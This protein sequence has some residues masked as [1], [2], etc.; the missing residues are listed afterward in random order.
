MHAGYGQL[1][2]RLPVFRQLFDNNWISSYNI[3]EI[4]HRHLGKVCVDLGKFFNTFGQNFCRFGQAY[5]G[6]LGKFALAQI[7]KGNTDL[8]YIKIN[9]C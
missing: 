4:F 3:W 6:V 1:W 9:S 8:G 2:A 7:L 5:T